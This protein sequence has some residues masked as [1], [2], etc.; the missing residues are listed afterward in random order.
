MHFI[1]M[2]CRP[3]PT[4]NT[5]PLEGPHNLS[6]WHPGPA[7]WKESV[8]LIPAQ[9]SRAPLSGFSLLSTPRLS[10]FFALV[11]CLVCYVPHF[12]IITLSVS[13]CDDSHACVVFL[14]CDLPSGRQQGRPRA[15]S[16]HVPLRPQTPH[17]AVWRVRN[18]METKMQD[19]RHTEEL[20]N[21]QKGLALSP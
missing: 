6:A 13:G 20:A 19:D 15:Y 16:P 10:H 3:P 1:P 4:G 11:A 21:T 5:I 17:G 8:P 7:A 18:M 2:S 14:P 12:A 9:L